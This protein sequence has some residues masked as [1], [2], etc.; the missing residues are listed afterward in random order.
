M[1]CVRDS[2][3]STFFVFFNQNYNSSA[4]NSFKIFKYSLIFKLNMADEVS[5]LTRQISSDDTENRP[6]APVLRPEI[7]SLK[8]FSFYRDFLQLI[9]IL[10]HDIDE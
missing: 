9:F 6:P 10:A 1:Q 2:D 8:L 5:L 7:A 4:K 3:L